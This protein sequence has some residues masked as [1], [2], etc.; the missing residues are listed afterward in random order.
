MKKT[1][2]AKA[3]AN[4]II[5]SKR[6]PNISKKAEKRI[7]NITKLFIKHEKRKNY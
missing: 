1:I 7:K 4:I 3:M 6:L 5:K 2:S